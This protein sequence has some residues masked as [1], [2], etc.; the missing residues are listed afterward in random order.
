MTD[1]QKVRENPERSSSAGTAETITALVA[2]LAVEIDALFSRFGLDEEEIEDLLREILLL[3]VYRWD[4][5]E[6]REL[7]L[8]ATLRRACL[9]RLRRRAAPPS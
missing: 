8:L 7:W 3:A 1:P 6:S 9:R 5:I 2:A 4:Q